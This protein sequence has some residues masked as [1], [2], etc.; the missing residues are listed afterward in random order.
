MHVAV[1]AEWYPSPADSVLGV[2]AHR[3]AVA[4]RDAG[5]EVR[6]IAMRR[7]IP[8][9][10]ALRATLRGGSRTGPLRDWAAGVRATPRAWELDGIAVESVR[11]VAPPRPLS[12]GSWGHW[13]APPLGRALSRLHARWSLDVVHAHSLVPPG[14]AAAR[15]ESGAGAPRPALVVST[16]GPDVIHVAGASALAARA[17]RTAL[18][19][20][21]LV[22]ANSRWAARRCEQ[23]SGR[24]LPVEVVHLGADIP[25]A[26]VEPRP[27][28]ALVTVAH[29]VERKHHETVLRALARLHGPIAPDYV[30]IGDGPCLEPLRAL[31]RE[32]GLE[33]RVE[34][35]GQ[36]EH[37]RA[38]A[39]MGRC[40]VFVMPGVEE[41]FGVAF[42]EAMAAGLPAIGGRGEGGPEDI[43]A[44]GGGMVLVE[45]G[46]A[47]ALARTI[48]DVLASPERLRALGESARETVRRSFTWA[49]CGEATVAAYDRACRA[50]RA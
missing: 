4:A 8:P 33:G 31:V 7:P 37:G 50:A 36:L 15:W 2:W 48:D 41:P 12:Y 14:F 22:M 28:P 17:T 43:A 47:A 44:A 26:G 21:D 5:A 20:A 34:F 39:E 38:L 30:V 42:V 40:A 46:D 13:M 45:P 25:P 1:V 18:D 24:T 23:I 16:H 3:Q 32:L 29:L 49:R 19:A 11:F 9:L 6:V 10:S 35:R 27:R